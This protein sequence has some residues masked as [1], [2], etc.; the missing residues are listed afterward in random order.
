ME[1]GGGG[2]Y[3]SVSASFNVMI[4]DGTNLF[5]LV[6]L[7]LMSLM[8][9]QL[10][11]T[12][13]VIKPTTSLMGIHIPST[14]YVLVFGITSALYVLLSR[15]GL[16]SIALILSCV[17]VTFIL[18][19]CVLGSQ[20]LASGTIRESI[21]VSL[22]LFMISVTFSFT[23]RRVD[24]YLIIKIVTGASLLAFFYTVYLIYSLGVI[25]YMKT[26]AYEMSLLTSSDDIFGSSEINTIDG[27]SFSRITYAGLNANNLAYSS[28]L[29][30]YLVKFSIKEGITNKFIGVIF[31]IIF[32]VSMFATFSRQALLLL[33]SSLLLS[34]FFTH[35]IKNKIKIGV[36]CGL[37][38]LPLFYFFPVVIYRFLEPFQTLTGLG[39]AKVMS[40][41]D[42]FSSFDVSF[43]LILRH[44]FGIGVDR[45]AEIIQGGAGEHNLLLSQ[46]ISH[47]IPVALLWLIFFVLITWLGNPRRFGRV[48]GAVDVLR[49]EVIL[50]LIFIG[51]FLPDILFFGVLL[52]FLIVLWRVRHEHCG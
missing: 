35:K 6:A 40:T 11:L 3:R 29:C 19:S 8:L 15:K 2:V 45:Y 37:A 32:L 47:G 42:R 7:S 36:F 23:I 1:Y 39:N 50:M 38:L 16:N 25:G 21:K 48:W 17:S 4:A 51:F 24:L 20:Y 27:D 26:A 13:Y 43:D 9:T 41:S 52:S 22:L 33:F 28:L 34:F 5:K 14:A 49:R 44:P 31:S 18:I 46:A 12:V 30:F 10:L